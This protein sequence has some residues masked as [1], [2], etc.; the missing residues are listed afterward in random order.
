[1]KE[2]TNLCNNLVRGVLRLAILLDGDGI[3]N[4]YRNALWRLILIRCPSLLA[5]TTIVAHSNS[6]TTGTCQLVGEE[7][8]TEEI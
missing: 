5:S 6:L 2:G 7:E 1:M 3:T 8:Q 4:L